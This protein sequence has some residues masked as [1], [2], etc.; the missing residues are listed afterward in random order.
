[1]HERRIPEAFGRKIRVRRFFVTVYRDHVLFL[2]SALSFDALL[3][4]IPLALLVLAILGVEDLR[5]VIEVVMPTGA[6]DPGAPL[7]NAERII[8]SVVASR[9]DL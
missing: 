7:S 5:S 8:N 3:A 1:M 2:A 9:R 4:A 6:S